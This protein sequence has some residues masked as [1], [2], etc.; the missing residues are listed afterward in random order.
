M[1]DMEFTSVIQQK[2]GLTP[3]T[4][5]FLQNI[6]PNVAQW[7]IL[8]PSDPTTKASANRARITRIA[9]EQSLGYSSPG[10]VV[11]F[12]DTRLFLG[13]FKGNQKEKDLSFVF[14]GG[15]IEK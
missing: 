3:K 13:C 9:S 5:P 4:S 8:S 15:L 10:P 6:I 7:G 11:L 14:W 2:R 12:E 1:V